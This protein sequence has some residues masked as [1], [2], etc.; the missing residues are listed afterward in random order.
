[1]KI[2]QI[3][4]DFVKIEKIHWNFKYITKAQMIK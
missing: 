2:K 3:V 1:M 4:Y